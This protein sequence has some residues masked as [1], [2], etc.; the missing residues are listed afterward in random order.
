MPWHPVDLNLLA[1]FADIRSPLADSVMASITWLGSLWVLL[2]VTVTFAVVWQTRVG[3]SQG[4]ILP[5]SVIAA[6]GVAHGLKLAFAR[7]RPTQF[8]SLDPLPLDWAFPSAHAM[9]AMACAVAL[10]GLLPAS[11]RV[12]VGSVCIG[13]AVLVGVS[14][15][16]LQVHWPS[17]VLAGLVLGGVCALSIHMFAM[18][19]GA[20]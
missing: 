14:R 3:D 9:Q 8:P 1:F 7:P 19:G 17:D 11:W 15:L 12:I 18:A 20:R 4:W 6:S 2:P 5:A 16:Y 13:L 10:T